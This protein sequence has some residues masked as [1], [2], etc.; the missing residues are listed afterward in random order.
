[1]QLSLDSTSKPNFNHL[2][3]KYNKLLQND[4]IKQKGV[5]SPYS[6]ASAMNLLYVLLDDN[7][8]SKNQFKKTFNY[9]LDNTNGE[10]FEKWYTLYNSL[11]SNALI[12]NSTNALFVDK[13]RIKLKDNF[14]SLKKFLELELCDFINNSKQET[15]KINKYIELKTNN[16]I[17]DILQE[18]DLDE[19]TRL[20]LVNTLY[21]KAKWWSSFKHKSTRDEDFTKLNGNKIKIKRMHNDNLRL[22]AYFG[23]T[24]QMIELPYRDR[25]FVMGFVLSDN[26]QEDYTSKFS[27]LR[28]SL[29]N[30]GIPKFTQDFRVELTNMISN[31]GLNAI[32]NKLNMNRILESDEDLQVSNIVQQVKVIV[33]EEGTE[34]A[35]AT[36]IMARKCIML[37]KG[38]PKQFMVDRTFRY[39]IRHVKSNTILFSGMYDA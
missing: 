7:T 36:I 29:V 22:N 8:S 11:K 27:E 26:L 12:L 20:V 5:F 24:L 25:S 19:L 4:I 3:N 10:C 9:Y 21:F 2:V 6:L 23:D 33:D 30:V 38:T 39:Y 18:G 32:F 34:A 37:E 16:M 28:N 13:N 17:K 31:I 14:D 1:M 35:A 15:E